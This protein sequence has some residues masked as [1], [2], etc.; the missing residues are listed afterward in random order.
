MTI[1]VLRGISDLP[2][3]PK[4]GKSLTTADKA[5]IARRMKAFLATGAL[6]GLENKVEVVSAP[7]MS[8][9]NSIHRHNAS[10]SHCRTCYT[11]ATDGLGPNEE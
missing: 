10:Q 2:Y 1:E 11:A 8:T 5:L 9:I 4:N 7:G 6:E 3:R